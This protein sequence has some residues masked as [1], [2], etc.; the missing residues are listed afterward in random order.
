MR[1]NC[2]TGWKR[3][4]RPVYF[5]RHRDAIVAD[6]NSK[7]GTGNWELVWAAKGYPDLEFTDACILYYEAPCVEW[8]DKNPEELDYVCSFGECVDNAPT[9][10]ESGTDYTKQESFSTHIQDIAVRNVLK[11]FG[12]KFIG[13]KDRILVIRSADTED[14]KYGPGNIPFFAPK[15]IEVPS[16]R[17]S[18]ANAGS[19][20]D[21]WQS[22]K[23]VAVKDAEA[24]RCYGK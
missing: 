18:W 21:F 14:Y 11:I 13:P 9:N 24:E 4:Y 22:N 16:K 2:S 8:F 15:P 6:L 20:E 19:V 1:I 17:P 5:G 10:I 7:Y 3:L 12:R 23:Y